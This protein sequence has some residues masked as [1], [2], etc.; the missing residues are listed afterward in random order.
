MYQVDNKSKYF[1]LGSVVAAVLLFV[2]VAQSKVIS[3]Q[4]NQCADLVM[5]FARG[6]SSN[7]NGL[8]TDIPFNP[9]FE[10]GTGLTEKEKARNAEEVPGAFFRWMETRIKA[11]YQ[12]IDYKAISVHNSGH[13]WSINGYPAVGVFSVNPF[14][15]NFQNMFDA[16][17]D[18]WPAGVYRGSVDSGAHE[19]AAY[20]NDEVTRCPAQRIVVGGYS[21]GAHVV[22]EALKII[23]AAQRNLI[24]NVALFGDPKFVASDYSR[25]NIFQ[26][27]KEFPW[28]RGTSGLREE[29]VAGAFTPYVPDDMKYKTISW[30][31]EDDFVCT[32]YSGLGWS[33]TNHELPSNENSFWKSPTAALGEGHSRYPVFGVPEATEEI[34]ANLRPGLKALEASRGGLD[35]G[36]DPYKKSYATTT[37]NNRPIDVMFTLNNTGGNEDSQA[38]YYQT[39]KDT[40]KTYK[41][42]FTDLNTGSIIY[43]D[44]AGGNNDDSSP[45]IGSGNAAAHQS[46]VAAYTQQPNPLSDSLD[47]TYQ[48]TPYIYGMGGGGD[49]PENHGMAVERAGMFARWRPNATKHIV[50]FAERPALDT[51]SFNVCDSSSQS[52]LPLDLPDRCVSGTHFDIAS[53]SVYCR[54]TYDVANNLPSA[55]SPYKTCQGPTSNTQQYYV[56]R[57]LTDEVKLARSMGF[58]VDIIQPH[59]SRD[60]QQSPS[61]APAAIS[62]QLKAFAES[63]GGLYLKYDY[64]GEAQLRDAVWQILNHQPNLQT[65]K[66]YMPGTSL[67]SIG[68]ANTS[69]NTLPLADYIALTTNTPTQIAANPISGAESYTWDLDGDG[70]DD[71]HTSGPNVVVT[72]SEYTNPG[73]IRVV[74]HSGPLTTSP[75]IDKTYLPYRILP[76]DG[77][78]GPAYTPKVVPGLTGLKAER[79]TTGTTTSA[80]NVVTVS[81]D[82]AGLGYGRFDVVIVKDSITG[83]P[84]GSAPATLGS[85]SYTVQTSAPTASSDP[86]VVDPDN[87][88]REV[89]VQLFSGSGEAPVQAALVTLVPTPVV[90][91]PPVV[92]PPVVVV[93]TPPIVVIPPVV[94]T[95]PV[96]VLPPV[97]V[98][99]PPVVDLTSGVGQT[100]KVVTQKEP[101]T[102]LNPLSP[103]I[104][105]V[106]VSAPV[107]TTVVVDTTSGPIAITM[108]TERQ[109]TDQSSR[110][111]IVDT[112]QPAETRPL[113][114]VA[115]AQNK[116]T[117]QRS[118]TG[119][120]SFANI[121]DA[122]PSIEDMPPT[123][124]WPKLGKLAVVFVL[125]AIVIGLLIWF[126]FAKRRRD[127]EED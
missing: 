97:P 91:I 103:S 29:G 105:P 12:H 76:M 77:G 92:L 43:T 78:Q 101:N 127:N 61:Y 49:Y 8:N 30:C 74:A 88:I 16:R 41:K 6:S 104:K 36:A 98:V 84:I 34:L 17:I 2:G 90:V 51:W 122:T 125:A 111:S 38:Q 72:A 102:T 99:T 44:M 75:V 62:G 80:T 120:V 71:Q 33:L 23:P 21:Q 94:V 13:H 58:T 64:F 40:L 11:D 19:L 4:T 112:D 70:G 32:S 22:H 110:T 50:V 126:I 106:V 39:L 121:T 85:Y 27:P 1:F 95:P 31:H 15:Q 7:P 86:G 24:D 5:L 65:L 26:T 67:S 119:P 100:D 82:T 63:T 113:T 124:L 79:V 3:N 93:V 87:D 115:G 114:I 69:L 56:D 116:K 14:E 45:I 9:D 52:Q 55:S 83:S 37:T 35:K 59:T 20:V 42:S 18:W 96:V 48:W 107:P 108:G 109:T 10:N 53:Q 118:S 68:Q 25:L 117:L 47:R 73:F 46:P 123:P 81:W 89:I 54:S 28:H 60:N 66:S 57:T